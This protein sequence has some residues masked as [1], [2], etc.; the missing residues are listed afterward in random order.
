METM[1]QREVKRVSG[2][3]GLKV[4]KGGKTPLVV[5]ISSKVRKIGITVPIDNDKHG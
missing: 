4:D 3:Y 1:K 2:W 5:Y